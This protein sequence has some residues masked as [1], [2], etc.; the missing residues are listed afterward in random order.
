[1]IGMVIGIFIIVIYPM[2]KHGHLV[3][4]AY[5]MDDGKGV[6]CYHDRH[7]MG[8]FPRNTW[9]RLMKEA[10]F[11]TVKAVP[12]PHRSDG[13]YATPNFVGVMLE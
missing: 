9:L 1:M 13:Y 3:D 6:N 7:R 11:G 10:G 4:M 5:V 8:L 12:Y 2:V